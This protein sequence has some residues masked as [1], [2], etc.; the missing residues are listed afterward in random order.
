MPFNSGNIQHK[1]THLTAIVIFGTFLLMVFS[2]GSRFVYQQLPTHLLQ[3]VGSQHIIQL[4]GQVVIFSKEDQSQGVENA[5]VS[6]A[7]PHARGSDY[8]FD[9]YET[10]TDDQGKFS[11]TLYLAQDISAPIRITVRQKDFSAQT[12]AYTENDLKENAQNLS[13]ELNDNIHREL[14]RIFLTNEIF[15]LKGEIA[16]KID[17]LKV[18]K[19]SI[20]QHSHIS[21]RIIQ[22]DLNG[23]IKQ[24]ELEHRFL[25]DDSTLFITDQISKRVLENAI[26]ESYKFQDSLF[27]AG[28]HLVKK[29][30][31]P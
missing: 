24:L 12:W 17:Q 15:M 7:L 18:E 23:I 19:D 22:E 2:V 21:A 10:Y 28:L 27:H 14:S 16:H 4:N 1:F 25:T 13:L 8:S 6:F 3:L 20:Q 29:Q 31:L 9:I 30:P 11:L 5:S 26:S